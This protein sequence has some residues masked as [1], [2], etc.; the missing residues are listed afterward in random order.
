MIPKFPKSMAQQEVV[1]KRYIGRSGLYDKPTYDDPI[2]IKN[3]V[4][5]PQT[6][7]SGTNND[8][9]VVANAVLFLYAGVSSPMPT[10]SK[11][12]YGSKIEFEEHEYSVTT[13]VDNRDPFSN[14]LW[15]YELEV[16]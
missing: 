9:T 8:R 7:Y 5:Q 4:F 16:L 12:N 14:Q 3:C 6:V 13:I 10:L 11:D 15:S 2:T 1:L